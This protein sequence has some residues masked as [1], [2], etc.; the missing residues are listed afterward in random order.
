[1]AIRERKGGRTLKLARLPHVV[2][3][4]GLKKHGIF[5]I[6]TTKISWAVTLFFRCG[7]A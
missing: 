4:P 6:A 3:G 2:L 7:I 1:M 5:L